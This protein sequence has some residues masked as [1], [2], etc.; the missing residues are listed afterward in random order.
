MRFA[1]T[2]AINLKE[3]ISYS[4]LQYGS[5]SITQIDEACLLYKIVGQRSLGERLTTLNGNVVSAFECYQTN[6]VSYLYKSL[7]TQ[8]ISD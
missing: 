6:F 2:R 4:P 5:T 7:V 1:R 8:T 3:F